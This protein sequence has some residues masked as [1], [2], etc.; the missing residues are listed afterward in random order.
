MKTLITATCMI[1]A[2]VTQN[3]AAETTAGFDQT[4][5]KWAHFMR[6]HVVT[7]GSNSLI[8]YKKIKSDPSLLQ[9]YLQTIG[10]VSP[11]DF[12]AWK[13]E[14][15]IS[16]LINAYNAAAVKLVL[17]HYP[18]ESVKELNILWGIRGPFSRE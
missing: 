1:V 8:H 17:D 12:A 15:K 9:D 18:I 11:A 13:K 10:A 7:Q 4:H 2:A 3:A 6:A 14:N 16:L 5:A